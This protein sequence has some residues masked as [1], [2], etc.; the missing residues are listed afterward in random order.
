MNMAERPTISSEHIK[1]AMRRLEDL[2]KAQ[3]DD[4]DEETLVI[5]SQNVG[6]TEEA[7]D[8]LASGPLLERALRLIDAE[9]DKLN[10][11]MLIA[12][13]ALDGALIALTAR[14]LAQG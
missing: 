7:G 4:L 2:V 3:G 14:D 8:A 5:A 11:P 13:V 9:G 6:L 1:R 10:V 12:T